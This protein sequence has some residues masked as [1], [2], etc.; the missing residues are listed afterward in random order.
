MYYLPG[1]AVSVVLKEG[2]K[3]PEGNALDLVKSFLQEALGVDQM[4]QFTMVGK[5]VEATIS[6]V[7]IG[8]FADVR[9]PPRLSCQKM[10]LQLDELHYHYDPCYPEK[11]PTKQV[12]FPAF[13]HVYI[14]KPAQ[15]EEKDEWA[16]YT[17]RTFT[18]ISR[19]E[20]AGVLARVRA[21]VETP[22]WHGAKPGLRGHTR[23]LEVGQSIEVKLPVS[24][25]LLPGRVLQ[26]TAVSVEPLEMDALVMDYL[27]HLTKYG[28]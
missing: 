21:K 6:K 1:E 28:A 4:V 15:E 16:A 24:A 17:P 22:V 25:A 11:I 7:Q 9:L 8:G 27:V 2:E 19:V 12:L 5:L 23:K 10:P 3:A 14:G 18:E 26:A 20:S 13:G